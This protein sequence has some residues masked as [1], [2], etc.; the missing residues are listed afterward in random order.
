MQNQ[1]LDD[2]KRYA[3]QRLQREYGFCAIAD[4][5]K[6]ALLNSSSES[7]GVDISIE[8]KISDSNPPDA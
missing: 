7:E 6:F 4:S 1:A 8:I 3:A 5:A 2:I